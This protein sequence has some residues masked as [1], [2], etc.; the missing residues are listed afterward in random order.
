MVI[1]IDIANSFHHLLT[2]AER[3]I[4]LGE[5]ET[6]K[7]VKDLLKKE[8]DKLEKAVSGNDGDKK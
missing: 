6:A 7:T 2:V 4:A 1:D 8:V 5:H 3:L